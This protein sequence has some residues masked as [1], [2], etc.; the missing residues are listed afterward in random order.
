MLVR[1]G[2]KIVLVSALCA[3]AFALVV[4]SALGADRIYW[5]S[6]NDGK[7]H[8]SNLDG[9]GG[10]QELNSTGAVISPMGYGMGGAIDPVQGRYYWTNQTDGVI[11][12]AALDGSG[13]GVLPT[14]AGTVSGPIGVSVDPVGR[15]AYWANENGSIAYANLDG[16]GGQ[17]LA[18]P[19]A[20]VSSPTGTT[21]F[22][23]SGRVYWTNWGFIGGDSIAY[24]NLDGSGGQTLNITGA[25]VD[26]PFGIAIDA[27]KQRLYWAND[28]PGI[29]SVANLDGSN[30][31]DVDRRGLEMKG[32]Y[33]LALD[34]EAGVAYTANFAG[35]DLTGLRVDGSGG[36]RVPIVLPKESG[37][38]FPVIYKD[39]R[40]V[41]PPTIVSRPRLVPKPKGKAKG[42]PAP[43][44]KLLGAGLTCEGGAWQPDLVEARLYRAPTSVAFAWTK[45]G[46]TI[47]SVAGAL[48]AGQVG[49]YRCRATGSNVA[50][51]TSATSGA[52][53]I[54]ATGKA[55]QN[56][57]KGT[58]LL[59]VLLPVEPGRLTLGGKGFKA[60]SKQAAGK[61]MVLVKPKGAKKAK[62]AEQGTLKAIVK[63]TYA[64]SDGPAATLRKRLTLKQD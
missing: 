2:S 56:L 35:N 53:A 4:A 11:N 58:V 39:P 15:R 48:R 38:D 8:W 60:V 22:P 14:G 50:G 29:I 26:T 51:S 42:K 55:K 23:A 43:L 20:S 57:R 25:T 24:A 30:A 18:T 36:A 16:S 17:K 59:T 21:V 54:F 44:P 45:D 27:A 40:S 12:W 28:N 64:P 9:S 62:L 46:A 7:V 10:V 3:L 63:L 61:V 33:G 52:V 41:A 19:G 49:N 32:P 31:V 13:G 34:P 1:A 5:T 37:P 6:F 47:G